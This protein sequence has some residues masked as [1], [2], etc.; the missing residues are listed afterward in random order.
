[1]GWRLLHILVEVVGQQVQQSSVFVRQLVHES[2][3]R[4]HAILLLVVLC[5][6]EK[7]LS[8]GGPSN[9]CR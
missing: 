8:E 4:P 5:K 3:N 6:N 1:M 9:T 7:R 2:V